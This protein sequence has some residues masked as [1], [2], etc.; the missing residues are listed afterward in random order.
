MRSIWRDKAAPVRLTDDEYVRR[1]RQRIA[2]YDRWGPWKRAFNVGMAIVCI[3][4]FVWL[5]LVLEK[6]RQLGMQPAMPQGFDPGFLLGV[7]LGSIAGGL[8]WK[9][10]LFL[11]DALES[12]RTE[13]LLLKYYDALMEL[14][15][16]SAET[17]ESE[18]HL[19]NRHSD[20]TTN[21]G[22]AAVHRHPG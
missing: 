4:L 20:G 16:E 7:V 14:A 21:V 12:L 9:S 22:G 19:T 8:L 6:V 17:C 15:Q 3:G 13:R 2:L 5:V 18:A 11:V 1:V 10:V